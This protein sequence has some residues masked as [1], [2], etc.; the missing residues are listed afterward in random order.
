[1]I[2]PEI[3]V[4]AWAIHH[5]GERFEN[6]LLDTLDSLAMQSFNFIARNVFAAGVV[7][8]LHRELPN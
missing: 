4:L 7:A 8:E 3:V 6:E 1:V 5:G 2:P